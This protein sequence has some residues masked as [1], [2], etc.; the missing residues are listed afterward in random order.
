MRIAELSSQSGTSIA[1][2][3][4]Y[5]REGLLPPGSATGRNQAD[6]GQAHLHRLRLIRALIDVGGLSVAVARDVLAV[7]E[8]P[9][10]PPHFLLGAASDAL[11][12]PAKRDRD[13]PAWQR[14][15]AVIADLLARRQWQ[16]D[17]EC[18]GID[19]A[20][21]AVAAFH[22]LG[23]ADMLGALDIYADAVEKM[24]AKELDLVVARENPADMVEGVITGTVIGEA[25]VNALRRLAQQDASARR[26]GA[27]A[28]M[29]ATPGRDGAAKVDADA[30]KSGR[31]PKRGLRR[32]ADSA[33]I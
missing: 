19:L 2:I 7:V 11:Y 29:P 1:S 23:Q 31:P 33:T 24:A 25:L 22:S 32:R 17:P 4:F 20:A 21:D 3:K 18:A 13:D 10:T 15:R 8:T 26:L 9:D 30:P 6:Y 16:V 28:T 5:L 12:R 27:P 14:S